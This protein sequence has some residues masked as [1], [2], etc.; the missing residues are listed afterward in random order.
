M[1]EVIQSVEA[2]PLSIPLVLHGVQTV[3]R[4]RLLFVDG[5]IAAVRSL[6]LFDADGKAFPRV[7]VGKFDSHIELEAAIAKEQAR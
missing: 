4:V 3:L 7:D 2:E 6:R 1:N 5:K